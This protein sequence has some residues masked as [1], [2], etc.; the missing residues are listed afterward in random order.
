MEHAFTLI[1]ISLFQLC[2]ADTTKS[3]PGWYAANLIN[4]SNY[5]PKPITEIF[6]TE[7]PLSSDKPVVILQST[8]SPITQDILS[9]PSTWS[10]GSTSTPSTS[11][12]QTQFPRI[13]GGNDGQ[14]L[15]QSGIPST[16]PPTTYSTQIPINN[17]QDAIG[18]HDV[19]GIIGTLEQILQSRQA[20]SFGPSP[21]PT[22]A[23]TPSTIQ[24]WLPTQSTLPP[25][26]TEWSTFSTG[27]PIPFHGET[28]STSSPY[29]PT[30][31]PRSKSAPNLQPRRPCDQAKEQLRPPKLNSSTPT[32]LMPLPKPILTIRLKAPKGSITNLHINPSTTTTTKKPSTTKRKS[33]KRKSD[34]NT[35]LDSCKDKRDPIC[36]GP[37][38]ITPVESNTLKGFPSLCHMAC[39][40]SFRKEITYEKV[41]DGRC[42]KLRT[43]I[44]TIEKNKIKREDLKKA[45]YTVSHSGPETIVEFSSLK[46]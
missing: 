29:I 26:S 33:T 30:L 8:Q 21:I 43:R 5:S 9:T 34:Y 6:S 13:L 17:I 1:A 36:S 41:A 39:H 35:C 7:S 40:N 25:Q 20:S 38:G 19:S 14:R 3:V 18:N 44:R 31:P 24:T 42:G 27:S 28:F 11:Y 46:R 32:L 23:V 16:L 12:T 22:V 10:T 37:Q 45:Q 2:G 4:E 15:L